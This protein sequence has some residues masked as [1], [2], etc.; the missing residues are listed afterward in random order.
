MDRQSIESLYDNG[1]VVL[2]GIVPDD[3]WVPARRQLILKLGELHA[4]AMV[5]AAKMPP[6]QLARVGRARDT[7]LLY[8]L[9]SP[10]RNARSISYTV[11]ASTVQAYD[12]RSEQSSRACS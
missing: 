2:K 3:V 12:Q 1:F 7:A 10:F 5:R 9:S 8:V 11:L 4:G 6:Q